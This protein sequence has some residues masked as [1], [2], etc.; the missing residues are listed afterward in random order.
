M[1]KKEIT[2]LSV[3]LLRYYH[4][5]FCQYLRSAESKT[6]L[7]ADAGRRIRA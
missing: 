3:E 1:K 4:N 5:K 7:V 6:S 2:D